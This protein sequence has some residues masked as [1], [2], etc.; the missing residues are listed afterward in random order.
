[1]LQLVKRY[2]FKRTGS[3][4]AQ[5]PKKIIIRPGKYCFYGSDCQVSIK[6]KTLTNIIISSFL[7]ES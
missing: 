4:T 6:A 5:K 3:L 2:R 7:D 1:M